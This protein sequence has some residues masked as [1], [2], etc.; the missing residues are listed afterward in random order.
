MLQGN[1][2][3]RA[4][5]FSRKPEFDVGNHAAKRRIA[6]EIVKHIRENDG[7]FLRKK[8]QKGP[9]YKMTEEQVRLM[10][11]CARA[12]LGCRLFG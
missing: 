6:T 9:W 1:Q 11:A 8:E 3:F 5:C 4:L 7:H 2:K 12:V 10:G